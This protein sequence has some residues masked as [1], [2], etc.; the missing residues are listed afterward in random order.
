MSMLIS[1]NSVKKRVSSSLRA[2]E[3]SNWSHGGRFGWRAHIGQG[4]LKKASFI[5]ALVWNPFDKRFNDVILRFDD[6]RKLFELEMNVASSQEA[7]RFYT[8]YEEKMR[9]SENDKRQ[10]Q[11]LE[12]QQQEE[13]DMSKAPYFPERNGL[14]YHNRGPRRPAE[15][16][17]A[18]LWRDS[19]EKAQAQ[20]SPST[21]LWLFR[22]PIFKSWLSNVAIPQISIGRKMMH[23]KGIS[24]ITLYL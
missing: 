1:S 3:V 5:N 16:I 20:R 13:K 18:P 19:F 15:W 22:E 7:L 21:G 10:Q 6:H 9:N 14:K 12:E 24:F 11:T 2:E 4:V 17:S 8:T 23:I